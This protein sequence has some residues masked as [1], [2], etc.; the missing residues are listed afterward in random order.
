MRLI[1]LNPN[2][3]SSIEDVTDAN[4]IANRLQNGWYTDTTGQK[5]GHALTYDSDNNLMDVPLNELVE[6]QKQGF[7]VLSEKEVD[8]QVLKEKAKESGV[9]GAFGRGALSGATFGLVRPDQFGEDPNLTRAIK[10]E[11]PVATFLGELVG[12][13]AIPIPGLGVGRAALTAGKLA[14]GTVGKAVAKEV[15]PSFAKKIA[16]ATLGSAVEGA[17]YGTGSLLEERAFN[18]RNGIDT[19]I[20][21]EMLANNIGTG[22]LL[23]GGFGGGLSAAGSAIGAVRKNMPSWYANI[24]GA[25]SDKSKTDIADILTDRAKRD[26][27]FVK[28][29]A[30]MTTVEKKAKDIADEQSALRQEKVDARGEFQELKDVAKTDL[31]NKKQATRDIALKI[32]SATESSEEELSKIRLAELE[33]LDPKGQTP[34]GEIQ[35][36]VLN[37]TLSDLKSRVD[38]M[39]DRDMYEQAIVKRIKKIVTPPV[40]EQGGQATLSSTYNQLLAM[41]RGLDDYSKWGVLLG[42]KDKLTVDAVRSL[43]TEVKTAMENK[44]IFGEQLAE[45]VASVNKETSDFLQ[46]KRAFMKEFG[47]LVETKTGKRPVFSEKKMALFLQKQYNDP[48]FIRKRKVFDDFTGKMLNIS[49]GDEIKKLVGDLDTALGDIDVLKQSALGSKT[50]YKEIIGNISNRDKALLEQK[51]KHDEYVKSVQDLKGPTLSLG[52]G[53]TVGG[54]FAGGLPGAVVGALANKALSTVTDPYELARNISKIENSGAYRVM[55]TIEEKTR[56]ARDVTGKGV[57]RAVIGNMVWQDADE[58]IAK[59][60]E[61]RDMANGARPYE[62]AP[63]DQEDPSKA[64]KGAILQEHVDSQKEAFPDATAQM[65]KLLETGAK[66]LEKYKPKAPETFEYMSGMRDYKPSESE[67]VAYKEAFRAV[68][69]PDDVMRQP[70]VVGVKILLELYPNML[71][72]FRNSV[73]ESIQEGK[74]DKKQITGLKHLLGITANYQQFYKEPENKQ[75]NVKTEN[76]V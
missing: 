5:D 68:V 37:K 62:N 72:M 73:I 35:N 63:I 40:L 9:L 3:R 52:F 11:S 27:F 56:K 21:A 69:S 53:A 48:V 23:G 24:S 6:A 2:G 61:A 1:K 49:G 54:G 51:A 36:A 20:T 4:E 67:K 7:R 29:A 46:S 19:G 41:K 64:K 31:T 50:K 13:A 42:G 28:D 33:R 58:H 76:F 10:E 26:E 74:V 34:L 25:L 17:L 75:A 30:G 38:G 32:K 70:T 39:S 65:G 14:A 16:E 18:E 66:I 60:R 44:A 47:Q 12:G 15:A 45:K 43:R 8:D 59:L 71:N 57:R 55:K 22:L